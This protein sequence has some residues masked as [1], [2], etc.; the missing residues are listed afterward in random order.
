MSFSEG[1]RPAFPRYRAGVGWAGCGLCCAGRTGGRPHPN[2]PLEGEGI[3]LFW[4][5]FWAWGGWR[6]LGCKGWGWFSLGGWLWLWASRCIVF[7][8]GGVGGLVGFGFGGWALV[9]HGWLVLGW[10]G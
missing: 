7:R 3:F 8:R 6:G 4:L 1:K 2:P 9:A 5:R 10:G